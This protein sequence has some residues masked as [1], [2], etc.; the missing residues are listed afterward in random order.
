MACAQHEWGPVTKV[1]ILVTR[2][3][4]VGTCNDG[5]LNGYEAGVDC[6]GDCEADCP[7]N[8]RFT[9]PTTEQWYTVE[10]AN[11]GANVGGSFDIGTTSDRLARTDIEG[12]PLVYFSRIVVYTSDEEW[13]ISEPAQFSFDV[14]L[15]GSSS[16]GGSSPAGII[17]GVIVVLLLIPLI[18]FAIVF[19]RR[20][21]AAKEKDVYDSRPH[22]GYSNTNRT[23]PTPSSN[24]ME[25]GYGGYGG[26]GGN[27]ASGSGSYQDK[28][29]E[30]L[31]TRM[32]D[33]STGVGSDAGLHI[34]PVPNLGPVQ[35]NRVPVE[36]L[37]NVINQ[38]SANS[39]FAF[40][41]EYEC[42]ETGNE[43]SREASQLPDNKFKNR[44][45]NILA[46]DYTRVRLPVLEGEPCSDYIN[47]NYLDGFGP[48]RKQHYIA[49][50][51]PTPMTLRDFWRMLWEAKTDVVVMVTNL[52]EKGRVKCQ[53][54]W[55]AN[56]NDPLEIAEDFQVTL[57]NE[58]EFPDYIIRTLTAHN[59]HK[60]HKVKQFH[61]TS[62]PD[63]GVP[64]STAGTST[65]LKK[66]NQARREG[67]GQGPMVVHCSAGVGRTG[68]I[69]AIDVN[70]DMAK[71]TDTVDV[72]STL[73]TMRRQRNTMVQT[74][75]QYIFIYRSLLDALTATTQDIPMDELASYLKK[76][77]STYNA[78]GKSGV[79]AE[80][81]SLDVLIP[82]TAATRTDSAQ[83]QANKPKNRFQHVLPYEATRVKLT[84]IPG[85]TGSD[86]INAN[87]IDGFKAKSAYIA[88]QGPLEATMVDFWRMVWEQEI[89]VVV[90]LT[91]LV[92]DGRTKSEQYWPDPDEGDLAIGNEFQVTLKNTT[93]TIFGVE[94]DMRLVNL[95][96]ETSR[97]V[98]HYQFTAW[99]ESSTPRD[100]EGVIDLRKKI[101]AYQDSKIVLPAESIYG[102]AAAIEEQARLAQI[103]P[104]VVHCS[105][106]VGRTGAFI[107]A[108][109][110]IDRL[111]EDKCVN[112]P[113]IVKHIRTQRPAMVQTEAQYDFIYVILS[114]A[115]KHENQPE[116]TYENVVSAPNRIKGRSNNADDG[117]RSPPKAPPRSSTPSQPPRPPTRTT[118]AR[119]EEP[120]APPVRMSRPS[121]A[122]PP[123][124]NEFEEADAVPPPRQIVGVSI[125]NSSAGTETSDSS[126]PSLPNKAKDTAASPPPP[127][128]TPELDDDE[129]GISI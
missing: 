11:D 97:D 60:T 29:N 75:E 34:P 117:S 102:N 15:A 67:L 105:A 72:Y 31:E 10:Y 93:P 107:T 88:T 71:E 106:G 81:K 5:S 44:Y 87:F 35:G 100:G 73:N 126:P 19:Y 115:I 96:T 7:V 95:L 38:M 119:E 18:I 24:S 62:W 111:K 49:A 27:S 17:A 109:I 16:S 83:L 122:P 13:S 23:G 59:G 82:N 78:E 53:R 110:G 68:T 50:Q 26:G 70:L 25:M 120:P 43:F 37:G 94:R 80:F 91:N 127:M 69:I 77:R 48:K 39:D 103:K 121:E 99:T 65:L 42:L 61:Y 1:V 8:A 79:A 98:K 32:G 12:N 104:V 63:H 125:R 45:A 55:P 36:D 86:Y 51:G 108:M 14:T 47:A 2:A 52:E 113:T 114:D 4:R 41:E 20:R 90:M 21:E 76:L 112:I 123:K 66:A 85:V 64:E 33:A 58:E 92:E 3:T 124:P 101:I 30:Y 46:Y 128:S 22:N 118:P 84:P 28:S 116:Q 57:D 9:I 89:D 129:F 54:Y 74:E 40:S 56:S 6:G